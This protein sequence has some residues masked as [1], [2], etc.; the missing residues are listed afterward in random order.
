MYI[1]N[2][3][4]TTSF[5]TDTFTGNGST[6]VFTMS[7]APASTT[8]VLVAVFGVLQDPST[9]TVSGTTLTFSAA[10]PSGTG[11][12]SVR[13]LGLQPITAPLNYRFPFYDYAGASKPITLPNNQ[14]LPFYT[15]SGASSNISLV[16]S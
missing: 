9:Y 3:P 8:S 11:C 6:T 15:Y 13:Y 5:I 1:G 7:L 4:L 2:Q 10:P 16:S 12:I 14:Y